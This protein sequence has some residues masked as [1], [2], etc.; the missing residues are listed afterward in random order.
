MIPDTG[1][2]TGLH[3]AADQYSLTRPWWSAYP[4]DGILSGLIQETKK[5]LPEKDLR[6]IRTGYL[7]KSESFQLHP[8]GTYKWGHML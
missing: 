5:S 7:G 1:D 4:E 6:V 2:A 8:Y 3:I